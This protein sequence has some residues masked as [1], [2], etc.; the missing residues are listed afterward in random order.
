MKQN[1]SFILPGASLKKDFAARAADFNNLHV[2]EVAATAKF[3]IA[4]DA[5]LIDETMKYLVPSTTAIETSLILLPNSITASCTVSIASITKFLVLTAI[6]F[7]PFKVII[8]AFLINDLIATPESTIK[9]ETAFQAFFKAFI[10][11]SETSTA[12]SVAF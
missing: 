4:L 12:K 10:V 1:A 9:F 6:D 11:A 3:W 8:T 5:L 2:A 7:T